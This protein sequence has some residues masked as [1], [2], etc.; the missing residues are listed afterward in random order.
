VNPIAKH[1]ALAAELLATASDLPEPT[2]VEVH[3]EITSFWWAVKMQMRSPADLAQW[4]EARG[5]EVQATAYEGHVEIR[6]VFSVDDIEVKVW[7]HVSLDAAFLAGLGL[8][9]REPVSIDLS[10]LRGER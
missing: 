6:A 3:A 8:P 2:S 1:A 9:L 5:V 7:D 4:A 10:V